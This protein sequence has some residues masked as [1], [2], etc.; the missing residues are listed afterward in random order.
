[1]LKFTWCEFKQKAATWHLPLPH[2]AGICVCMGTRSCSSCVWLCNS[3]FQPASLL[4]PWDSPGTNTGVGCHALLQGIFLTQGSNPN[5]LNLLHRQVGSLPLVPPGKPVSPPPTPGHKLPKNKM[6]SSYHPFPPCG[7]PC[8]VCGRHS[9]QARAHTHT[10]THSDL[11]GGSKS[12]S[13]RKK[14][15]L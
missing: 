7:G 11:N 15:Q 13:G 12:N 6:S 14:L 1:M 4:C 10:H 8:R 9:T 2:H 5:L 3:G